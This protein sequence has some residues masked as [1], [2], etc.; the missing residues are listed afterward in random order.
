MATKLGVYNQALIEMKSSTIAT[1]GA[2]GVERL[3]M[4]QL[5]DGVLGDCLETGYWKFAMRTVKIEADPD[6]TPAFGKAMA[7]NMPADWVKTYLVSLDEQLRTPFSDG[8]YEEEANLLFADSDPL[9]LRYV[10][11]SNVGF[12]LDLTRWT[13]KYERFVALELAWR[14]CPKATGSSESLRDEIEKNRNNARSQ[15]LAFEAHREPP[16]RPPQGRWNGVR[17]YGRSNRDPTIA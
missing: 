8:G 16:K 15:A 10:S 4:D 6:I 1:L 12:G 7:F 3:V 14:A 2:G 17:F 5:Y 13:K 11:N 9:Y